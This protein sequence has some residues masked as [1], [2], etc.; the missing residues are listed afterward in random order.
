MLHYVVLFSAPDYIV[1]SQ[2][3][4]SIS[5]FSIQWYTNLQLSIQILIFRIL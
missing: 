2:V 5:S 4:F 3:F 1:Y